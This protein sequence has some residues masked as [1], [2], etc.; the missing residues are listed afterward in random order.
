MDLPGVTLRSE[1]L[2]GE[3][4]GLVARGGPMTAPC[5]Q[6]SAL[7]TRATEGMLLP[8]F[9]HNVNNL[10]VGAMGNLDLATMFTGDPEKCRAKLEES[11]QAMHRLSDFMS[12]LGGVSRSL[13]DEGEP[14]GW[15]DLKTVCTLGRLACGRSVSLE[16]SPATLPSGRRMCGGQCLDARTL[17]VVCSSLMAAALL[18]LGGC[19]SIGVSAD[20]RTPAIRFSWAR[21]RSESNRSAPSGN[22][23][24]CLAAGMICLPP[25]TGA[26]RFSSCTP[27][28]G[29]ALLLPGPQSS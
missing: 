20:I 12:D 24:P 8:L 13:P 19:G 1:W 15:D 3:L 14:A 23:V 9:V 27:E 21:G 4:V 17:R 25:D 22:V 26:L 18:S 11:S 28:G 7:L 16:V 29:E 10:M 6:W 5:G 2:L